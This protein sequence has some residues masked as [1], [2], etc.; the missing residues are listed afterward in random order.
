M[1]GTVDTNYDLDMAGVMFGTDKSSSH[2]WAWDYLRHYEVLLEP[3]RDLPINLL[4]I[5]VAGGPSLK[6]WQSHFRAAT[7][8]GIDINPECSRHAQ[9]RAVVEIGSQADPAFLERVSAKYPPTIVIDDGSH[10]AAHILFSFEHLFPAL[11]PGGIYIVE[12]AAFHFY[13]GTTQPRP[14]GGPPMPD[15]FLELARICLAKA[16]VEGAKSAIPPQ[17]IQETDSVLFFNGVIAIRK[18]KQR[19]I[20]RALRFAEASLAAGKANGPQYGRAAEYLLRHDGPTE[21]A[22]QWARRAVD[23]TRYSPRCA[24]VLSRILQK[25]QRADEALELL[26]LA[27]STNPTS[28]MLWDQIGLAETQRNNY[29]AAAMAYQK[30]ADLRPSDPEAQNKLSNALELAGEIGK[31]LAAAERAAEIDRDHARSRR[32]LARVELLRARLT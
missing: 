15:Y 31:A 27:A 30:L 32:R 11:E 18:R 1:G 10:Q 25:T 22:E 17:V 21:L 8:V 26:N 24:E 16:S 3:W 28:D 9:G 12:D 14:F 20:G 2:S 13:P 29:A 23:M 5:G 4:E 19:D 7:I 6:L